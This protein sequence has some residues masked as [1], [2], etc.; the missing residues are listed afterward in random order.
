MLVNK[1][2]TE[3]TITL[4]R[5]WI[6]SL[7][8]SSAFNRY[9]IKSAY[10]IDNQ[11]FY[12][13]W[14]YQN[15][16][17]IMPYIFAKSIE[18]NA[19]S[20]LK[21]MDEFASFYPMYKLT[22]AKADILRMAVVSSQPSH[23]LEIGSFLG[24]SAI[25]IASSMPSATTLTCIEGN[26]QNVVVINELLRFAFRGREEI[27]KRIR[28][29]TGISTSVIAQAESAESMLPQNSNSSF[30]MSN[31]TVELDSKMTT[32]APA[33]PLFDFVFLDH[34]KDCYRKDLQLLG[35]L[36]TRS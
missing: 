24:Y 14:I 33:I 1:F 5:K 11:S 21:A 23:I 3:K 27:L 32:T 16:A 7:V 4:G 28:L 6:T 9:L 2:E 15:P 20:V 36:F 13:T 22:P 17:D 29:I 31:V 18:G 34:D 35:K 26:P 25:K 8:I 10:A 12:E 30:L 19:E